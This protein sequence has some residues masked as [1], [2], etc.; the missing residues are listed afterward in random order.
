MIQLM[1]H[2]GD[3]AR[4]D[5]SEA[6]RRRKWFIKARQDKA[7]QEEIEDAA[8][9]SAI[10]TIATVA[11]ATDYQIEQFQIRLH[12]YDAAVTE[13]IL[14]NDEQLKF[15]RE[16]LR[17]VEQR[18][19]Q[20]LD[21]AYVLEDGRRVFKSED[22]TYVIDEHGQDVAPEEVDFDLIPN[23]VTA[24]SYMEKRQQQRE[25]LKVE[26]ELVEER[27]QLH[28]AQDLIREKEEA[29]ESGKT[30]E[31]DLEEFDKEIF[32]ALPASAKAKLP[33]DMNPVAN[34]PDIKSSFIAS[35]S[36]IQ[37]TRTTP[38]ISPDLV[39]GG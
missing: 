7:R 37:V 8:E 35:A 33:N 11:L 17:L 34:A 4:H 27:D 39:P 29:L 2:F 15:I 5:K 22:G 30:T 10:S 19:Q 18:I 23:T 6:A 24:E 3:D 21:E 13:A 38:E 25:A 31:Q 32:D 14:E 20:M 28:H 12:R 36:V 1:E 26:Q 16:R 9:T